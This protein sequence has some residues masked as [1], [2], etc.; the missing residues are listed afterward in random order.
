MHAFNR[1]SLG[2]LES[3]GEFDVSRLQSMD[4]LLHR[5]DERTN[6][7][8]KYFATQNDITRLKLWILTTFATFLTFFLLNVASRY[9]PQI[10]DLFFNRPAPAA[11][12]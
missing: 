5:L 6:L 8:E 9:W 3:K 4:N 10:L 2:R 12:P 7:F 1:K 11:S